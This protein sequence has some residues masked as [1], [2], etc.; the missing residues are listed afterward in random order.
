MSAL[1]IPILVCLMVTSF[2]LVIVV[3]FGLGSKSAA[4]SKP[5]RKSAPAESPQP[6]APA[7]PEAAPQLEAAPQPQVAPQVEAAP[8]PEV[9]P[10]PDAAPQ[11]ET[12][13]E[14]VAE[15]PGEAASPEA[16]VHKVSPSSPTVPE[17]P[18]IP[19]TSEPSSQDQ[20]AAEGTPLQEMAAQQQ[21]AAEAPP[22][23]PPAST[24]LSEIEAE[25]ERWN[26]KPEWVDTTGED[27][28]S[29]QEAVEDELFSGGVPADQE[30][31]MDL[32]SDVH[33]SDAPSDISDISDLSGDQGPPR[34]MEPSEEDAEDIRMHVEEQPEDA[35]E[36]PEPEG[37]EIKVQMQSPPKGGSSDSISTKDLKDLTSK[38][39]NYQEPEPEQPQPQPPRDLKQLVQVYNVSEDLPAPSSTE[40]ERHVLDDIPTDPHG[41]S[42]WVDWQHSEPMDW[43]KAIQMH[44]EAK[45]EPQEEEAEGIQF[46]DS[47]IQELDTEPAEPD[48][49]L[50]DSA[51]KPDKPGDFLQKIDDDSIDGD[52]DTRAGEPITKENS[53]AFTL[54]RPVTEQMEF[55]VTAPS[56]T[57]AG[58]A[59]RLDVWAHLIEQREEILKRAEQLQGA[60]PKSITGLPGMVITCHLELDTL[61]V[62]QPLN[63]VKWENDVGH[64]G[65]AVQVPEDTRP[66]VYQGIATLQVSGLRIA[67]IHFNLQV[68]PESTPCKRLAT[69]VKRCLSAYA[70]YADS[71]RSA[72]LGRILQLARAVP[73]IDVFIDVGSLRKTAKFEDDL[74][75]EIDHRDVLYL[76]WSPAASESAEVDRE[77]R[78]ALELRGL[79][80]LNPVPLV[81]LSQAPLPSELKESGNGAG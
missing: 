49:V 32:T 15:T 36:P 72:V 58:H 77:W 66:G 51:A 55:S 74:K 60:A 27:S 76:F 45:P 46:T 70:S 42:I 21:E 71:D 50:T 6:D 20:P 2:I 62:E 7:E 38:V 24:P 10:Q 41:S 56:I 1:A 64:A 67:R 26:T 33:P 44:E 19:S 37:A 68:G 12:P 39:A 40:E 52:A 63:C 25:S 17:L 59:C 18:A 11:E 28:Q 57:Q 22:P 54:P 65:F 35:E 80:Y 31:T 3:V 79:E 53:K 78:T 30:P 81:S 13:Q 61:T 75:R 73:D 5:K 9:T 4:K 34:Q 69:R 48:H 29:P 23:R 16:S 43:L 47:G 8:Q 14:A